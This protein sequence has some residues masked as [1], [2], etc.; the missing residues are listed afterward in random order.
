M[1]GVY[2]AWQFSVFIPRYLPTNAG[3]KLGLTQQIP[4][5]GHNDYGADRARFTSRLGIFHVHSI[6]GPSAVV[7]NMDLPRKIDSCVCW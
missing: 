3:R 1:A 7:S 5:P 2:R 6:F 4:T